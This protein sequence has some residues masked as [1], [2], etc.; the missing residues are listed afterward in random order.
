[1]GPQFGSPGDRTYKLVLIGDGAVGKTSIRERYLGKGFRRSQLATIGVDFAQKYT[2]YNGVNVRHIIWDLAGQPSYASV[3]RHYYRGS[4][5]IVLV[6]S[7]V[8]RDSF[9]NASRWLV[10]A[11]KQLRGSEWSG[12]SSLPTAIV[13]NKIDLRESGEFENTVLTEEGQAFAKYFGQQLDAPFLYK[14]TSALTGVNIDETF[15]ELTGLMFEA[16]EKR[17]PRT[18]RTANE[19]N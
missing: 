14:E 9:D 12:W 15:S 13:G 8:E 6:F 16:D 2:A 5:A 10:E 1:M 18:V 17:L 3:R 7:V 11:H 19:E 4:S